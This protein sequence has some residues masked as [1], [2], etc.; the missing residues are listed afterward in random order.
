MLELE[1]SQWGYLEASSSDWLNDIGEHDQS[2]TDSYRQFATLAYGNLG[3]DR[4][5]NGE[6]VVAW[7]RDKFGP[8]TTTG[9]IYGDGDYVETST[10]NYDTFIDDI[11]YV[12]VHYEMRDDDADVWESGTLVVLTGT[13]YFGLTHESVE[14]YR[15][16]GDDDADAFGHSRA[17]LGHASGDGCG[18]DWICED[19][20]NLWPNGGGVR[21]LPRIDDW[22][23]TADDFDG[24][25]PEDFQPY[26]QCP[27]CGDKLNAYLS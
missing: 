17:F 13:G 16:I 19:T 23:V 25:E 7:L 21:D 1:V 8:L 22:T 15:F 3:D 4:Y 6:T 9:G 20:V 10:C 18:M 26:V 5:A 2:L 24:D 11:S 14:V 12:F 27:E